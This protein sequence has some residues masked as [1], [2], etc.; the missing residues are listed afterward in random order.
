MKSKTFQ[1]YI[2]SKKS[3]TVPT[4]PHTSKKET[5]LFKIPLKF[6]EAFYI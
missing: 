5:P 2:S 3:K 4:K 6:E 1:K